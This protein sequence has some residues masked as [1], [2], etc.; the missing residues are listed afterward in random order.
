MTPKKKDEVI[1][2]RGDGAFILGVPAR[3][4]TEDEFSALPDD[5]R[6]QVVNSGLYD[7]AVKTPQEGE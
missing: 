5:V 6:K 4:L 3:D 7:F 2:Y 1:R